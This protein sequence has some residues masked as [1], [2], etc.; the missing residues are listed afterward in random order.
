MCR[1]QPRSSGWSNDCR[2]RRTEC[3]QEACN[4]RPEHEPNYGQP[5][6]DEAFCPYRRQL[7]ALARTLPLKAARPSERNL[8]KSVCCV[9][10]EPR[11]CDPYPIG[12]LDPEF[13]PSRWRA[14]TDDPADRDSRTFNRRTRKWQ[15]SSNWPFR[16]PV[17]RY[18]DQSPTV[19]RCRENDG[20]SA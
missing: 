15:Q 1:R 5:F 8:S 2:A 6:A 12:D 7:L 4:N 18:V 11:P 3:L 17:E 20:G 16:F 19:S 14:L 9:A 10:D 13:L